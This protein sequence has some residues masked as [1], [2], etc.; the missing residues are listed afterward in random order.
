M[1]LKESLLKLGLAVLPQIPL[2]PHRAHGLADPR[3]MQVANAAAPT[4]ERLGSPDGELTLGE[5]VV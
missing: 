5:A 2:A 1:S 4:F 3:A